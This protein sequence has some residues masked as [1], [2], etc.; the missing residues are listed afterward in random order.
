[1]VG[2]RVWR[3]K[4]SCVRDSK[5]GRDGVPTYECKAMVRVLASSEE[6]FLQQRR[7]VAGTVQNA[8]DLDPLIC[9]TIENQHLGKSTN[10]PD[11]NST[12]EVPV[13]V[14]EET[15]VRRLGE[16]LSRPHRVIQ[17]RRDDSAWPSRSI[18][19]RCR[20]R[21]VAEFPSGSR[22]RLRRD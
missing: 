21:L 6:F 5:A 1:M 7:N 16:K 13:A 11:M 4:G 2:R 22:C 19:R 9:G 12:I 3:R 18:A 15:S 8:D 10:H 14:P 17:T 20:V